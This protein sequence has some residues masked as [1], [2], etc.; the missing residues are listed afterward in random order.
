MHIPNRYKFSMVWYNF[1][2]CFINNF[3]FIMENITKLMH[4]FKLYVW[5]LKMWKS[6][7]SLRINILRH[8]FWLTLIGALNTH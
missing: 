5:I 7:G 1:N 4:R 8:L 3:T 2:C 6:L